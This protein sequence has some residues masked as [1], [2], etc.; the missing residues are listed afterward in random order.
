[1]G[2]QLE[3]LIAATLKAIG[4][5]NYI[6]DWLGTTPSGIQKGFGYY[7]LAD[8]RHRHGA[9]SGWSAGHSLS[10]NRFSQ[11][12]CPAQDFHGPWYGRR[13]GDAIVLPCGTEGYGG[14]K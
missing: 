9:L 13:R 2:P 12:C 8:K 7:F 4:L 11:H 14:F 10:F 1:M 5:R 3:I 6:Q